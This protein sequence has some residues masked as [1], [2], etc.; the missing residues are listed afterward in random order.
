[1]AGLL[2][3]M[4]GGVGLFLIGVIGWILRWVFRVV[5][6]FLWLGVKI[7]VGTLAFLLGFALGMG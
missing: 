3:F 4:L 7:V 6:F 1:M 5:G 2:V